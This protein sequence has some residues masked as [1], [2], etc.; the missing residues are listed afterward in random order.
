MTE[1]GGVHKVNITNRKRRARIPVPPGLAAKILFLSDR[2][3]CVCRTQGKR[4]QI[5]HI[6]GDPSNN[7]PDNLSVLCTDC[8]DLTMIKGG[9]H[10]HLSAE[11]IQLYRNDWI[12]LVA[13]SR[14]GSRKELIEPEDAIFLE[15]AT[16]EAEILRENRQYELLA[17]HYHVIGNTELRDKYI[18]KALRRRPRISPL[19]EVELRSM[20]GKTHLVKPDRVRA[21]IKI[22]KEPEQLS[23]LARLY[24]D[25][26]DWPLAIK[27]Y[28][29]DIVKMIEDGNFFSAAF[30]AK[31]LAERRLHN[32]L[33]EI[34]LGERAKNGDLWWQLRCLKELGWD[35][36]VVALM[37]SK[38]AE[39]EASGDLF[40][41]AEMSRA[42]GEMDQYLALQKKMTEGAMVVNL[43]GQQVV[44]YPRWEGKKSEVDR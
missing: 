27:T 25:L 31:E 21:A 8:H 12:A 34:E 30:Y 3:C 38:K 37:R 5:H 44:S 2:T 23:Q 40:L 24:V 22:L 28:C 35:S 11:Q 41:M 20:Q 14:A 17:Q 18:R 15:L 42:L 16:S 6:D 13:R 36:E 1:S 29:Q 39:I 33:F 4:I 43:G 10:R 32:R 9:F 19:A 7:Q 26:G